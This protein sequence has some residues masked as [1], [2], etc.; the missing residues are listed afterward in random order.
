MLQQRAQKIVTPS[1]IKFYGVQKAKRQGAQ[2]LQTAQPKVH[3]QRRHQGR[4]HESIKFGVQIRPR[5]QLRLR[6]GQKVTG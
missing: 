2:K 4:Q 1:S 3:R 6:E 5:T